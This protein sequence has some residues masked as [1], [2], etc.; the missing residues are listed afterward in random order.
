MY[1]RKTKPGQPDAE[2]TRATAEHLWK[3]VK[4]GWNTN[5]ENIKYGTPEQRLLIQMRYNTFVTSIFKHHHFSIDM[6]RE[7]FD[8]HGK[9]RSF[10]DFKKA[11]KDKVD[12]KYNKTWLKTEYNTAYASGQMARKW[13]EYVKKGGYLV[14]VAVMDARTRYDHANMN[15]AR[16]PVGH[17]FWSTHYP[18]NGFN[19]RC[20]T[21]WDGTEG[22]T[23]PAQHVDEIPAMFQ[24]NV[25]VT[26]QVFKDSPYFTVDGAF[27]ED[28]DNLFGFKTPIDP[29]KYRANLQL[30]EKLIE[31]KN[32][33][34]SFVDNLNGGFVFRS[35]K[36]DAA[37]LAM[38]VNASKALAS[39]GD[40]VIIKEVVNHPGAKNSD[41]LLN[42]L[43]A[44]IKTNMSAT[45][46]AI[47]TALR[48]G[49][50]QANTVV[51]NIQ[52]KISVSTLEQAIYNRVRRVKSIEKVIVIRDGVVYELTAGEIMART[53]YGKIK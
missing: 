11:V 47:D 23:V 12:P 48:T 40:S 18:P 8:E 6:A 45:S 22:E 44:E 7:L 46:N 36:A 13:Q 50:D 33:K 21:R 39:Q 5:G 42:G 24:N 27:K 31:D 38:N 41:I 35:V 43:S 51:L 1:D 10:S 15:G 20:T 16:Y 28:A 25:G 37:E 52:S 32:F 49:K 2:L 30:Y 14:Y 17:P 19:C 4:K 9:V 3:G 53:F 26:G 29:E 34:I